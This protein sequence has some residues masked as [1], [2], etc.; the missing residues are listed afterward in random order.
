MQKPTLWLARVLAGFEKYLEESAEKNISKLFMLK[1]DFDAYFQAPQ[2]QGRLDWTC[3]GVASAASP[4]IT[5]RIA[6]AFYLA[7]NSKDKSKKVES[8][9][10]AAS[11]KLSCTGVSWNAT[12]ASI[13][14]AYGRFDHTGWCNYRSALCLWSVF[15]SDFNPL[16]PNLV[17]ETS[18]RGS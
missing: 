14:V 6:F 4:G 2:T 9:P 17:L 5:D 15:Q 18:V 8:S 16:K 10:V 3:F 13:A 7:V 12:G 11:L 1:F